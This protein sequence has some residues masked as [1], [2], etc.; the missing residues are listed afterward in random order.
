MTTSATKS[1]RA[2]IAVRPNDAVR[3][4][5]IR[6]QR[7]LKKAL[8]ISRLRIKWTAPETFHV[9]LL[10]LGD[11]PQ[12]SVVG[13]SKT[14]EKSRRRFRESSARWGSWGVLKKRE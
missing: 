5:L 14:L 9:T 13:V 4:E 6:V 12:K 10:F 11:I 2:F 3:D 8:E 7:E 1:I